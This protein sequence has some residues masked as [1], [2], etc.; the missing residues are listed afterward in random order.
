MDNHTINQQYDQIKTVNDLESIIDSEGY[1]IVLTFTR[2]INILNL[3]QILKQNKDFLVSTPYINFDDDKKYQH[4][5]YVYYAR[6]VDKESTQLSLMKKLLDDYTSI[7]QKAR[8]EYDQY[9]STTIE[10]QIKTYMASMS[11]E[12]NNN[13]SYEDKALID[14]NASKYRIEL[15]ESIKPFRSPPSKASLTLAEILIMTHNTN[16]NAS[17]NITELF[18]EIINRIQIDGFYVLVIMNKLIY[19][20]NTLYIDKAIVTNQYYTDEAITDTMRI[21]YHDERFLL[22][23]KTID[24]KTIFMIVPNFF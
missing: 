11:R 21:F 6:R 4:Q 23:I 15:I 1:F 19:E 7:K 2:N 22:D 16:Y 13:M 17:K 24:C 8:L 10:P 3:L 12:N 9:L 14:Y 5:L 18:R 20:H